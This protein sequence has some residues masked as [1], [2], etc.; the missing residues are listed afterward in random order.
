MNGWI[1][2][3]LARDFAAEKTDA[4]RLCTRADGWVE[5]FGPDILISYKTE[6]A[7]DNLQRELAQWSLLSDQRCERI[8]GR[9]LPKQNAERDA[10]R[11]LSGDA[12]APLQRTV[13]ERG[14]CY[15]LDFGAGYSAGLF[16]DQR[17]NR[18]F[19]RRRAPRRLLNC[20][21]YTCSFSVVAALAGAATLSIDLSRKSLERG[22]DNFLLNKLA[23]DGHRFLADDV[24]RVLPRL[25]R[26]GELF[27]LIVLDPP[28]FSRS[29]TGKSWQIER[30]FENLLLTALDLAE[31]DSKILLSTNCTSLDTRALEVMGR[32][33]LKATR[34]AG[35]FHST[36]RLPD[37]PPGAGA[38]SLW[39][40]LR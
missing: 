28:T 35:E 2:F 36:G 9:Y 13:L 19:V 17:E 21:S 4:Y 11:L 18:Q 40:L 24:L 38:R 6:A 27:D 20:F 3:G 8:F 12:G 33:C 14:I 10:P 25:A 37:F 31:R 23:T 26:K 32:F 39:M 16:L 1:D 7:C 22:R 29:R 15:G 30:D 5:R 34:R